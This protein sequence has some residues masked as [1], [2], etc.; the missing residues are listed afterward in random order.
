MS[1]VS[2]SLILVAYCY[3]E[4]LRT[5]ACD[6]GVCHPSIQQHVSQLHSLCLLSVLGGRS[7]MSVALLVPGPAM[8]LIQR[9]VQHNV[10]QVLL[11]Q[12]HHN[13]LL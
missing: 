1:Y 6:L 8:T 2:L 3:S 10:S 9:S 11:L 4:R 7:T 5:L 13:I 12:S